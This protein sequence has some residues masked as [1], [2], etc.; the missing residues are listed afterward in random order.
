MTRSIDVS[1][2]HD[3]DS[4]LYMISR[5]PDAKNWTVMVHCQDGKIHTPAIERFIAYPGCETHEGATAWP[6]EYFRPKTIEI[7]RPDQKTV[8]IPHP[9]R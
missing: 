4:S 3:Y 9:D 7:R 1:F 8:T 5:D 6:V 2:Q